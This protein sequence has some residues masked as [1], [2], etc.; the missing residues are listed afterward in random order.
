MVRSFGILVYDSHD[1]SMIIESRGKHSCRFKSNFP[2]LLLFQCN[3]PQTKEPKL[4]S[5][6]RIVKEWPEYDEEIRR[7]QNKLA[8]NESQKTT[9]DVPMTGTGCVW[10]RYCENR[11]EQ[12]RSKRSRKTTDKI[13]KSAIRE[14]EKMLYT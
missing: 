5:A 3:N 4:N 13:T 6:V 2:H 8:A 12:C 10:P 7:L 14:A 1:W 9:T 11:A